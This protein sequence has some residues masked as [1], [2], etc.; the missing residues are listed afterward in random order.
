MIEKV[1]G[2]CNIALDPDGSGR[3][4]LTGCEVHFVPDTNAETLD[5]SRPIARTFGF[6]SDWGDS[7]TFA[8]RQRLDSYIQSVSEEGNPSN[9]DEGTDQVVLLCPE[10]SGHSL[11]E[12]LT[13]VEM[14]VSFT[15]RGRL[16]VEFGVVESLDDY[17][18]SVE[19]NV[20]LLALLSSP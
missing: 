4:L 1:E 2:V 11:V 12:C 8:S 17:K 3:G 18:G 10:Y 6:G 15:A 13:S 5:L 16:A 19:Q 14:D 20:T 9:V 7:Q